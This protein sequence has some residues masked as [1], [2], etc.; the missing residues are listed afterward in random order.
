MNEYKQYW[1]TFIPSA[2][3]KVKIQVWHASEYKS[4]EQYMDT[5]HLFI[6]TGRSLCGLTF[7][8]FTTGYN[9]D[10]N[11]HGPTG[12]FIFK[13]VHLKV[14]YEAPWLVASALLLFWSS[15]GVSSHRTFDDEAD[16]QHWAP[17]ISELTLVNI[18]IRGWWQ[19]HR[20]WRWWILSLTMRQS[21]SCG[22]VSMFTYVVLW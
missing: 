14:R 6:G 1:I 20:R 11:Y 13:S 19:R 22:R 5:V 3:Q 15:E 10:T 16:P 8:S 17:T 21:P 2:W 18:L 9:H 7:V 12:L 4:R